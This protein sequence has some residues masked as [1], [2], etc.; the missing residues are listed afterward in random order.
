MAEYA[1]PPGAARRRAVFGLLDAD[2]WTWASI[3]ALFWFLLIIFVLGYLPDRAY[4][5]T[6]S[7]TLDVGFNAISPVNLC[8]AENKTLP[9]PAPAGA[10]IPW[11]QSPAELALP[12]GRSA[13][14]TFASG[15][16]VY[17]I[18]GRTGAGPTAS[19]LATSVSNGNLSA[20][21]EG[22]ALPAPRS[23]AAV[24]SLS[25]TPYVIGGLDATGQPTATVFRGVVSQGVL[26]SWETAADLALPVPLADLSGA[27]TATG[28]YIFGGKGANGLSATT[29][30]STLSTGGTPRLGAWVKVTELPLP[31]ARAGATSVNQGSAIYVIGGDG[32]AGPT[33]SV[34]YLALDTHGDPAINSATK[35]AFGWGVSVGQSASA[36]LPDARSGHVTFANGGAIY[37]LGGHGADG[38]SAAT[39]YWAVP[40]AASGVISS[41]TR[42]DATDLPEPRAQAA[43]VVVGQDAFLVG[44]QDDAGLLASTDRADVSP[45]LPFFRLGLFGVTVPAL[46]IKGE[47]GQQ[48]GWIAAGTVGAGDLVL[49]IVIG[50]MFSHRRASYRFFQRITRGR[51]RAPPED[52]YQL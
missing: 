16:T 17:L 48:L 7:P 42:L 34:F 29:Y 50:W 26:S 44:G 46:S 11:E 8:P 37:V 4:Y 6:V 45:R 19:V 21:Q 38:K 1:L 10:V 9:C 41:W 40:N 23:D 18:G 27:S 22:P 13:A 2:G 51:F 33:N 3:K 15:E 47:I 43:A 31:E 36:A 24:I 20:W 5:F 32:P 35:R 39:N 28:L 49:L 12:D 14:G 52:E 25:G 30:R